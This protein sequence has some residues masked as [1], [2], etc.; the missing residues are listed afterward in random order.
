MAT[1]KS[2]KKTKIKT[3]KPKAA[4]VDF[5]QIGKCFVAV[6]IVFAAL[7]FALFYYMGQA[8]THGEAKRLEAFSTLANAYV[9]NISGFNE[10]SGTYETAVLTDIGV[11]DDDD[12]YLEYEITR[13][14]AE[15][16]PI[17]RSNRRAHFQCKDHEKNCAIAGWADEWEKVSLEEQNAWRRYITETERYVEASNNATTEE[18]R[19][20]LKKEYQEKVVPIIKQYTN[21]DTPYCE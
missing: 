12:L 8:K 14:D 4:S 7:L 15:H 10:T 18:E 9:D 1:K 17:A 3:T 20:A 11:T 21:E 2:T 19:E 5:N 13:T 6:G 16:V